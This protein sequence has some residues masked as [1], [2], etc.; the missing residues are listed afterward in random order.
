MA[1]E[2]DVSFNESI[3][4]AQRDALLQR[5]MTAWANLPPETQAA[6][7]PVL[8]D[9]HQQLA[10]YL[11]NG[12]P[13]DSSTHQTLRMKS[14]LT[15]DWD[16]Q[17]ARL[18]QPINNAAAQPLASPIVAE[19]IEIKVGS[20]GE[21]LGTGKYQQLDPRWELVAGTVWL[22]HILHKQP[23]PSGT[24]SILP[25]DNKVRIVMAGD[26]GTGNFGSGDSPSVK[27]S[28]FVPSLKPDYTIHL[29]DTY[30]A[31][32]GSEESNKLLSL[33]PQGTKASFA[34]NSNHE[35]Y[36]SGGPYFNEVVGGPIF[37]K[38]QSPYSFFA[39]ENDNWIVVGLDSAYYSSALKLYLNGTLGSNN[40]QITFL[41]G[42]AKR[43]KRVIVITPQWDPGK[44]VRSNHGQATSALYRR[45]EF[46]RRIA[47]ASILVLRPRARWCRIRPSQGQWNA[48]PLPWP[49][50]SAMGLC[51]LFADR[52][53]QRNSRLV[54]EVQRRGS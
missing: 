18:G 2:L 33:W 22:E 25:M 23:F 43:G 4:V 3:T 31:G 54:R 50:S 35:M 47:T 7:K 51:I 52:S 20:E 45:D 32:T 39:L 5:L 12:T 46:I 26:Y 28:K 8:D 6:I 49:C 41:Q 13:P 17:L 27:I 34:L 48:V 42:I 1:D 10:A 16:G 40:A 36:S 19:A 9:G 38:L 11:D 29:G 53:K 37:N 24:P 30:Y 15:G 44:W 14:Y 21:I